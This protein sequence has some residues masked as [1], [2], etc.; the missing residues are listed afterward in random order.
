MFI[1]SVIQLARPNNWVKNVFV[2]APAFFSGEFLSVSVVLRSLIAFIAFCLMSSAVYCINDIKDSERDRLHDVKCRRPVAA[3]AIS[4]TMACS[5]SIIFAVLSLLISYLLL[6]IS[7]ALVLIVYLIIN[8]L[9]S[10]GLNRY[11]IID[12]SIIA[13][14]FVLRLIAGGVAADCVLSAWIIIVTFQL[15]LFLALGKRREDA[16]LGAGRENG[17]RANYTVG[18]IDAAMSLVGAST[19]ASYFIYTVFPNPLRIVT[20]DYFYLTGIPVVIGVIR[21]LQICI[22]TNRGGCHSELVYRDTV[23]LSSIVMY[24]MSFIVLWIVK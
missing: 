24:L 13:F 14:G 22:D 8:L 1:R 5:I 3:G 17:I 15:S 6:K 23:I 4:K 11:S 18:F 16:E 21:Y 20:S 10:F 7:L 9:Y 2:F 19:I 12:I